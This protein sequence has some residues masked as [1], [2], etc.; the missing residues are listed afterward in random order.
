MLSGI[1]SAFWLS[2]VASAATVATTTAA[3]DT[4]AP[5]DNETARCVLVSGK[6]YMT[7]VH[8]QLTVSLSLNC[9][10]LHRLVDIIDKVFSPH[11][12]VWER[13]ATVTL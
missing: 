8:I 2:C 5:K 3:A 12:A 7:R 1:H 4:T 6:T 9:R 10:R 11:C 13:E